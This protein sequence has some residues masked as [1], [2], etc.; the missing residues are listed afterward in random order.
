MTRDDIFVDN[1]RPA[2]DFSGVFEFEDE[3]GYFYLY[4]IEG[5]EGAKIIGAIHVITG[6]PDFKKDEVA[7]RWDT[8]ENKVGLFIRGRLWAAFDAVTKA[9]HGGNYHS[10]EQPTIPLEIARS[11]DLQ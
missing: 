8:A 1:T 11:F 7:V 10:T 9:K 5:D 2:G 6:T 3:T 4:Q